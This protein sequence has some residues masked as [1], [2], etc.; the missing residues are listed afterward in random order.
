VELKPIDRQFSSGAV[1]FTGPEEPSLPFHFSNNTGFQM[2]HDTS[3]TA[4]ISALAK[5]RIDAEKLHVA[6]GEHIRKLG[7]VAHD[8]GHH[9]LQ[10]FLHR[11]QTLLRD[12]KAVL[13]E[14]PVG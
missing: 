9:E 3:I 12:F 2:S 7:A 4:T 14:A 10:A 11:M 8:E 5:L 13:S 6:L 1:F